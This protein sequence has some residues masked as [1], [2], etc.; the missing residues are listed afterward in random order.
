MEALARAFGSRRAYERAQRAGR[1]A[2]APLVRDGRIER[3][4]GLG[5]WTAMR[6]LV[7]LPDESFRDWWR[8]R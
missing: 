3:V 5:A 1:L 7:A 6:D 4:P 8:R 2:Q